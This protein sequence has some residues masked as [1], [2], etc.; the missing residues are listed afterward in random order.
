MY[1]SLPPSSGTLSV[2]SQIF[3]SSRNL[4]ISWVYSS[5]RGSLVDCRTS[6]VVERSSLSPRS[7]QQRQG[8]GMGLLSTTTSSCWC[9]FSVHSAGLGLS[10]LPMSYLWS[11][12]GVRVGTLPGCWG[13]L[14]SAW[15]TWLWLWRHIS[16][17]IGGISR[18]SFLDL[19]FALFFCGGKG[20]FGTCPGGGHLHDVSHA[21][22]MSCREFLILISHTNS[23]DDYCS[24]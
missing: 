12:W 1:P 15:V 18:V 11:S 2:P 10:C 14:C 9:D 22:H 7:S 21:C 23:F 13:P 16:W 5:V 3:Q 20:L 4:P 24:S 17:G 6:S 8:W 19:D